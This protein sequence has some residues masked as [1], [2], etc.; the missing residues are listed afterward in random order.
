MRAFFVAGVLAIALSGCAT[1]TRG[2]S[3]QVELQSEPAEARATTSLGQSCQTP[4]TITV[5]RKDEFSVN[6]AK[7]GYQPQQVNVR[8]QVAGAGAA[9][10]A[11]NILFGG[12][13][14]AGT[15][16][17]TG[18]ALEHVPNPVKVDLVPNA[19]ARPAP[20]TKRPSKKKPTPAPGV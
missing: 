16:Y 17:V 20:M 14:G 8:T 3:D 1:I 12:I 19:P 10:M 18:A 5:S 6:F 4:C 9:G 7:E 2:T 11:G 15:D 13:I